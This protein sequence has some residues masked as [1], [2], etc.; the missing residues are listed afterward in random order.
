MSQGKETCIKPFFFYPEYKENKIKP[1]EK[2]P[3][4]LQLVNVGIKSHFLN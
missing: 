2:N 4:S 3:N 1:P